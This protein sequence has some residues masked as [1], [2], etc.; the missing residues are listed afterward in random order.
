M[1]KICNTD[2]WD[3]HISDAAAAIGQKTGFR[4]IELWHRWHIL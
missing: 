2:Y 3:V 1:D 4:Y